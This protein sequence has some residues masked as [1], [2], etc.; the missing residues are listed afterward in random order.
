MSIL[1]CGGAGY[2]GS[3]TVH[4]LVKQNK[5]V[6]IVDNLQSGHMKA[7]NPKAK[8]YKGDIRDSEF[9]DKV[10]SENKIDAIIHFAANSLVGESMVKPLLYFNNNV[11]GM[12]ILLESMV[13]HDIKN[14]V[15]SSTAAVYGEPKKIPISED[16]ETNPTN[17]YGETK[18]TMEKM[19]K[20]VSKANGINY[21]SL[22]YFNAAGALEDGSIGEDHSPESHLI[23]LILQVPLGK[24]EAITVFGEDY[25]TPD[26]TCIRDY[27]HV[28]DLADAH[29]KAV[30]YL[31]SGNESNIFNL[32]NG[33]G[34]SVKE[35][36]DSAKEAT[37]EEIKVV[38]G[39]R[40]AGDPARLIASNEKA[41]KILGWTPKY[42]DVKAIIKTAWTWHKNNPNGYDDK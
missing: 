3:H 25:D 19:M 11:Y 39:E 4:E 10:F 31:Q 27:I 20:W 35:M 8:F 18:L 32:G 28:L 33:I 34:F 12:Q 37:S 26:G 7:V 22:R 38:V 16:D 14:I 13:K 36:I 1:V 24:R 17:T 2:I 29:I 30:E 23:P 5:D 9:L 42:T 41:Q 6:I 21:V 40:R 15:F